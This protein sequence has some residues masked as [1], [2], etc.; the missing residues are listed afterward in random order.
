MSLSV[1]ESKSLIKVRFVGENLDEKSIPIYE[2]GEA[3][4][5]I[6]R[7]INKSYLAEKG[8]LTKYSRLTF[9]EQQL[10]SLRLAAHEKG[11]DVYWL[12]SFLTDLF[13]SDIVQ[14]I[15]SKALIALGMYALKSIPFGKQKDDEEEEE[16]NNQDAYNADEQN[17][18]NN[19]LVGAIHPYIS[20]LAKPIGGK[21]GVD[22]IEISYPS[23]QSVPI[24]VIDM[25]TKNYVKEVVDRAILGEYQEI[26]GKVARLYTDS[27]TLTVRRKLNGQIIKVKLAAEDFSQIRYSKVTEQEFVT[28][29][30]RPVYRLGADMSKFDEFEAYDVKMKRNADNSTPNPALS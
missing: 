6:Q 17:I 1:H 30:G 27:N 26:D 11:S 25:S 12:T 21:S 19:E 20:V 2:L 13:S 15:T 29:G 18:S 23:A 14:E 9:E 16:I 22:A 5:A 4:I 3:L 10:V 24:V 28:F 8:D 7:I